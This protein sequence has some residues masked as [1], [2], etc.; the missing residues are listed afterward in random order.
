MQ[1]ALDFRAALLNASECSFSAKVTADYG[2][3]IYEFSMDSRCSGDAT[4]ITVTQ[5]DSIS[6]ITAQ[7]ANDTG[8][9]TFDGM[10]LDFGLL[11]D[12]NLVPLA[13]PAVAVDCW[14]TG[15]IAS[16]GEEDG[17][18]RVHYERGYEDEQILVDTWFSKDVPIYVEISDQERCVLQLELLDFHMN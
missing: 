15:Y 18:Y 12:G 7:V 14:E 3:R 9:I 1:P 4:Q 17:N 13:A 6:G 11:A 10:S 5:P 2:D 8:A 16:A